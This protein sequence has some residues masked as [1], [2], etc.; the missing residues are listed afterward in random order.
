MAER[1][2]LN[3]YI[4]WDFDPEKL[5]NFHLERKR[6]MVVRMMLP[7]TVRCNHCGEFMYAG[8]KFNTRYEVAKGEDYLG[9]RI[10]RFYFKCTRCGIEFTIKT[11]PKNSQ[12][13]VEAGATKNYDMFNEQKKLVEEDKE[14]EEE[15][16]QQDS[17]KDLENRMEE[18]KRDL[19]IL[20]AL[21]GI[22][23]YNQQYKNVDADE[24]IQKL[25]EKDEKKLNKDIKDIDEEINKEFEENQKKKELEAKKAKSVSDTISF[26]FSVPSKSSVPKEKSNM[27]KKPILIKKKKIIPLKK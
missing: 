27:T 15:I 13:V 25:K 14:K 21:D 19:N 7:F 3:K 22:Q 16:K 4:P 11:D 8:K 17:I 12:Y 10:S 6:T 20:D 5:D 24:V 1:K 2:V 26:D 9:L 18:S 23:A